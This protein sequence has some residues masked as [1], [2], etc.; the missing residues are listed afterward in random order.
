M[1]LINLF[2]SLTVLCFCAGVAYGDY[3]DPPP[4]EGDP[5]T[6]FFT[7]QEWTFDDD[8]NPRNADVDNNPYGTATITMDP[9]A[10]WMERIG[11]QLE[12]APPYD[13]IV[14]RFGGW[15]IQGPLGT[16][17]DPGPEWY[18]TMVT[19]EIPNFYMPDKLKQLWIGVTWVIT[20]GANY[21][22]TMEAD[23]DVT[24]PVGDFYVD[25]DNLYIGYHEDGV[26]VWV[27]S[28]GRF[29]IWPQPDVETFEIGVWMINDTDLVV[30]D[31]ICLDTR[32]I[33]PEPATVA[34]LGLGGLALLRRR[35][36]A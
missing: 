28:W 9:R 35:K 11:W 23:W 8:T 2:L 26:G 30:V 13:P 4:W 27:Q 17:P 21:E 15:A 22:V 5:D 16:P 19:I 14:E 24:D 1:K 10:T 31:Q 12:M 36:R 3:V 6:Q 7:H 20:P 18:E 32:C 25:S 29:D 33:V 34:L